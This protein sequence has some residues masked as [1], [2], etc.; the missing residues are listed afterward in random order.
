MEKKKKKKKRHKAVPCWLGTFLKSGQFGFSFSLI[1]GR[2]AFKFV[3]KN[4]SLVTFTYL[5]YYPFV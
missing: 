1:K 3:Q 4:S 5:I 2:M